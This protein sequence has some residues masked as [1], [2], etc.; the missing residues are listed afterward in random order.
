MTTLKIKLL[1]PAARLPEYKTDGASGMDLFA[2]ESVVL[3]ILATKLI[4]LG[5]ALEIPDGFEAQIRPRSSFN[6]K[7]ILSHF[8]TIDSDYRGQISAVLTNGT[9]GPRCIE[10]GDR[11]AQLVIAPVERVAVELA[12]ELSETARGAGGFGSTGVR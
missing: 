3:D 6:A 9:R 4:P 7:G 10:P 1:H 8:G 12:T 5:I 11:I 2:V